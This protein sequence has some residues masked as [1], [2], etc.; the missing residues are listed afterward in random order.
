VDGEHTSLH[1]HIGQLWVRLQLQAPPPWLRPL[2][3]TFGWCWAL[4]A[5]LT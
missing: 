2:L 4:V 5:P 3:E 1:A